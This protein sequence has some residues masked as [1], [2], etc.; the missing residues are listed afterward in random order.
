M[1]AE[2]DAAYGFIR[3]DFI[4]TAGSQHRTLIDDVGTIANA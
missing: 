4:R 2:I 1:F 3:D